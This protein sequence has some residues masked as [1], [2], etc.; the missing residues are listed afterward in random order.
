M[1][2]GHEEATQ[3]APDAKTLSS[4]SGAHTLVHAWYLGHVASQ[5]PGFQS[6]VPGQARTEG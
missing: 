1:F 5:D 6:L 3:R 4:N 2:R